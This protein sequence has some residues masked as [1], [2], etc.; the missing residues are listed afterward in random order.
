VGVGGEAFDG[1]AMRPF[2]P[3][4]LLEW[5]R[6]EPDTS[7]RLVEGSIVFA[8]ISGFTK[9][10]EKLAVQGRVGAEELTDAIGRCFGALLGVAYDNGASLLKFG[11]DATLLLFTG[12]DH[13]VRACRSAAGMRQALR[14]LGAFETSGAKVTLRISMGAHS[15]EFPFFLLGDSHRELLLTGPAFTQVVD[16]ESTAEAGEIV[17]SPA[18]AA[19]LPRRSV[20]KAKGPGFLLTSAALTEDQPEVIAPLDDI[21]A[22]VVA[23]GLSTAVRAHLQ[24]GVDEPEHRHVTVAFLHFDG[25]DSRLSVEAPEAVAGDLDQL[26]RQV[27]VSADKHGVC[28]LG[29]DVDHDGGKIIL[30]AGAPTATGEDEQN[31]LLVLREVLDAQPRIPVRIGVN[32]GPVFVGSVGPFYRRTYTVM[33]DAVNLA[34]RVMAKAAPGQL[35]ATDAVLDRSQLRFRRTPLEPFMV[36][37]KSAP[38]QAYEVGEAEENATVALRD[39]QPFVGRE[40]ELSVL[41]DAL[42]L[43]R[44]GHGRLVEIVGD[45][46]VGK[47][48]LVQELIAELEDV[49]VLT[50]VCAAYQSLTPYHPFRALLRHALAI[51]DDASAV[52]AGEQL[53]AFLSDRAPELLRWS[54]LIAIPMAAEV[55]STPEVD[56]LDD[57]FVRERLQNVMTVFFAIVLDGPTVVAVD[58]AQWSD[59]ASAELLQRIARDVPNG[60]WLICITRRDVTSGFVAAEAPHITTLR[61]EP[62]PEEATRQLA[63]EL[64]DA[65]PAAQHLS[66]HDLSALASRSGGNPLFLTELVATAT[67]GGVEGLPDSVEAL[68]MARIDRLAPGDRALLRRLSVFGQRVD[69]ELLAAA[70]GDEAPSLKDRTWLRLSEVVRLEGTELVF[71]HGLVRDGAYDSLPFRLRRELHGRIGS[72]IEER[73][74]DPEE[75]AGLLSLHYFHAHRYAET[76]HH[77]RLAATKARDVYANAE[78]AEYYERA[79]VAAR[80]GAPVTAVELAEAYE[81]AGDVHSWLGKYEQAALAFRHATRSTPA[82]QLE[83]KARLLYKQGRLRQRFGHYPSALRWLARARRAA[84]ALDPTTAARL[85]GD[86]LMAFANVAKDQGRHADAMAWCRRAIAL[87]G[88]ARDKQTLAKAYSVHDGSASV[89]GRLDQ[90][91]FGD[92][93]LQL[94]EEIGDLCGLGILLGNLGLRSIMQ[95]KWDEGLEHWDRARTV[96]RATGDEVNGAVISANLAEAR[97]EQGRLEEAEA[98]LRQAS[99]VWAA[100]GDRPNTAYANRLLARIVSR[101]AGS[102]EALTLFSSAR[103]D[104]AA[105]QADDEVYETSVR[106]AEC[107]A[108]HG[109]ADLARRMSEQLLQGG[110][111]EQFDALVHRTLGCAQAQ[112]GMRAAAEASLRRSLAAAEES[113]MDIEIAHTLRVLGRLLEGTAE[114]SDLLARSEA[115][116]AQLDVVAVSDPPLDALV[117]VIV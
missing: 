2:A 110:H 33:G 18:T 73:A 68:I 10:S 95:G 107:L 67:S 5:L 11:G 55:A 71:E 39:E 66:P 84:G 36:K 13:A 1:A 47:T 35:L 76:W 105:A 104:F 50:T 53:I 28:F 91:T 57:Q 99:R 40:H 77:S 116:F 6:D 70:L 19:L 43:A 48:R 88:V 82:D 112:Q 92:R 25:T 27:Q 74:E 89:L 65:D 86:I 94:F 49:R 58:D 80:S 69:H 87:A 72:A 85:Q 12:D 21:G 32:A 103:E 117:P 8:D 9:L 29:T 16:M 59:E 30:V 46:G 93:A 42:E 14:D 15:G 63:E 51:A 54:P 3:R 113:G 52:E 79:I 101:K 111:L 26:V 38:V 17:I 41:R 22:D 62:L 75:V 34:A 37:G 90:A 56:Q 97:L 4:V 20:G 81:A 44:H 96:L 24:A 114:A 109:D 83:T 45:A 31:M 23:Q 78:A 102:A 106:I 100:A 60:P 115:L 98:A 7:F 64:A 108:L 61:A